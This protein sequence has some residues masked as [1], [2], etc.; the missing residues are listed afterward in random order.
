[1]VSRPFGQAR[2]L[3]DLPVDIKGTAHPK[4]RARMFKG[5]GLACSKPIQQP[6]ISLHQC[7]FAGFVAAEND[8]EIRPVRGARPKVQHTVSEVAKAIKRQLLQP[9]HV[10]VPR[11]CAAIASTA[12]SVSCCNS[13]SCA[14]ASGAK[15]RRCSAGKRPRIWRCCGLYTTP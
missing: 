11:I 10:P 7:G 2:Q 14:S 3:V 6:Q 8:V 15:A 1:M 13:A 5:I 12:S 4:V 9:H